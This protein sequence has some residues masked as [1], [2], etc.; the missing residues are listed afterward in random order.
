MEH[1]CELE[2]DTNEIEFFLETGDPHEDMDKALNTLQQL[3]IQ[4]KGKAT[5]LLT[6]HYKP[7]PAEQD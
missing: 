4:R 5:C 2:M 1:D 7:E 6:V 3:A